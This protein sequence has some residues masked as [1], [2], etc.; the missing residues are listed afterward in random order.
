MWL[1]CLSVFLSFTHAYTHLWLSRHILYF[2]PTQGYLMLA[3]EPIFSTKVEP[4]ESILSFY[5]GGG[6][7]FVFLPPPPFFPVIF[8][9]KKSDFWGKTQGQFGRIFSCVKEGCQPYLWAAKGSNFVEQ[10]DL[11]M[12]PPVT[13]T[14]LFPLLPAHQSKN[15]RSPSFLSPHEMATPPQPQCKQLLISAEACE[16]A[17]GMKGRAYILK[18]SLRKGRGKATYTLAGLQLLFLLPSVC[19][20][21][22]CGLADN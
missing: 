17:Y 5:V 9:H 15:C 14:C 7:H 8:V 2:L 19:G 12:Q 20:S 21:A 13:H 1:V 10:G 3:Q 16:N 4:G 6:V 11:K 22:G 18:C